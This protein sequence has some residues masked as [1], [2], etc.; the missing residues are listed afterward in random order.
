MLRPN[1]W[2]NLD[3]V[4]DISAREAIA[5]LDTPQRVER[6]RESAGN[7]A[8]CDEQAIPPVSAEAYARHASASNGFGDVPAIVP[9]SSYDLIRVTRRNRA[10]AIGDAIAL[11]FGAMAALARRL[12]LAHRRYRQARETRLM[13]ARL[14]DHTLRDLG[15][16]R[17]EIGSIAAESSGDSTLTRMRVLVGAQ[18]LP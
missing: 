17:S 12:A 4:D 18:W 11:A 1:D 2:G 5:H 13:L 14:D 3:L 10:L 7:D 15:F 9:I 16:D 8:S 6:Q